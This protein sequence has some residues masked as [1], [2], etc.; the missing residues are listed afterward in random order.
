MQAQAA[1]YNGHPNSLH[2]QP[3]SAQHHPQHHPARPPPDPAESDDAAQQSA[4]D[5]DNNED[6]QNE[7]TRLGKRKRP[8]A[9]S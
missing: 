1:R 4:D 5:A 3:Q 7:A 9:V 6:D 2:P 8:L